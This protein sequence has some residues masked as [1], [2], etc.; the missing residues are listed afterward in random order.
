[1]VDIDTMPE[2]T[3]TSVPTPSTLSSGHG[4]Q[5]L[6]TTIRKVG[7]LLPRSQIVDYTWSSLM[8]PVANKCDPYLQSIDDRLDF[9]MAAMSRVSVQESVEDFRDTTWYRRVDSI[10]GEGFTESTLQRPAE[11]FYDTATE[12]FIATASFPE[13]VESLKTALGSSW[14]DRLTQPASVFFTTAQAAAG[15]VRAGSSTVHSAFT[16][17]GNTFDNVVSHTDSAVDKWLPTTLD[18]DTAVV[19]KETDESEGRTEDDCN[20]KKRSRAVVDLASKVTRRVRQR[21]PNW[22]S[23]SKRV[24]VGLSAYWFTHVDDI[25]MQNVIVRSLG[26]LSRPAEHFYDTSMSVFMERKH[27]LDEFVEALK[28]RLGSVWDDRLQE[29]ATEFYESATEASDAELAELN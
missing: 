28:T 2:D 20:W 8:T 4:P 22:E 1:M 27:S 7:D 13:F 10:M 21:L 18:S 15:I 6:R 12:A 11:R 26:S 5:Y 29:S 24:K 9:V 16:F 19:E 3:S 23:I 25:L 14:D 17:V